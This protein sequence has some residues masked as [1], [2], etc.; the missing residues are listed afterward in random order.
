MEMSYKKC[1]TDVRF[2]I[3]TR[4]FN[5]DPSSMASRV[6]LCASR[7]ERDFA[8]HSRN[9]F[10]PEVDLAIARKSNIS[11]GALNRADARDRCIFPGRREMN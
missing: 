6:D 2:F 5:S 3:V 11:L 10:A 1:M 4:D 8:D 9:L 7:F